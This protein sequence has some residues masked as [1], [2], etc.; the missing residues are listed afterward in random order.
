VKTFYLGLIGEVLSAYEDIYLGLTVTV[1][2]FVSAMEPQ[3]LE[4]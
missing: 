2:A 3:Y 4:G 1:W